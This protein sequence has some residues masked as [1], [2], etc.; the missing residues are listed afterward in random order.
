MTHSSKSAEKARQAAVA[1]AARRSYVPLGIDVS[2]LR[3]LV[4]GGGRVGARKALKLAEGGARVVVLSPETCPR[5]RDA[6]GDG[7]I[8]WRRRRYAP[9]HLDGFLLVVAATSDPALNIRIAHDAEK[10]GM[11]ACVVSPGR[12]S[13]VIFPAT[14]TNGQVTVAVHSDGRDCARSREVRDEIAGVLGKKKLP[15]MQLGLLGARRT[16]LPA[17]VFDVL[18]RNTRRLQELEAPQADILFLSTCQRWECY[19]LARSPGAVMRDVRRTVEDTCGVLLEAHRG[20]LHSKFGVAAFHHLLRVVCGLDSP[21]RGETDIVGQVRSAIAQSSDG[22]H[23]ALGGVFDL[24]LRAQ[25]GIRRKSG[26]SRD[27]NSWARAIISQLEGQ[28]SPLSSRRILVFGWGQLSKAVTL[29]LLERGAR[30]LPF[31]GRADTSELRCGSE[32]SL[33]ARSPEALPDYLGA[34]D[35]II[36][37]SDPSADLLRQIRERMSLG[38][39]IVIDLTGHHGA[40]FEVG[41]RY[42]GPSDV[43]DVRLTGEEA[44]RIA[45]AEKLVLEH[46]LRWHVR[47]GA[48]EEPARRRIR[49]GARPSRLSRAQVEEVLDILRVLSPDAFLELTTM[50]SPCDRDRTTPLPEIEADDF[51]TRDLDDALRRGDIDLAVHSAKDLPERVPDGLCVAAVTPAFAPWECLVARDSMPLGE[52]PAGAKVGTSSDRRRQ[53]LTWLRPD[54]AACDVRGN[55]PDRLAQLD[56]GRYDALVLAAAGLIRLNLQHRVSQ[57]FSLAEFPPMAGQGSL[58]LTVRDDD[59][60]LRRLLEPLDLG[61]VEEMPWA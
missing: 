43:G 38:G 56:E 18:T 15:P 14:Y 58:A 16:D 22:R 60:E 8:E 42:F 24:C 40:D 31:S 17:E 11:L 5:L 54:L 50:D 9:S 44:A 25:R 45:L 34:G 12:F 6:I 53:R 26:L 35:A 1:A 46:A 33:L 32:A 7:A 59:E 28:I 57:V 19:C 30:V 49:V 13:R 2:G 21:L 55:V 37:S 61:Q 52:L 27:G 39:F 3:C 48:E 20:A 36:L 41:G 23:S 4:V 51:F 10:R 47:H 29:Q